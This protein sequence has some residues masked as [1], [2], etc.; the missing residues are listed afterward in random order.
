M[1]TKTNQSSFL[2]ANF[3]KNILRNI[4]NRIYCVL[5]IC[6][7]VSCLISACGYKGPPL[8]PKDEPLT[9]TRFKYHPST[10]VETDRSKIIVTI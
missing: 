2:L 5:L 3:V 7:I 6:L 1:A 10:L 9:Q 4:M 8:P